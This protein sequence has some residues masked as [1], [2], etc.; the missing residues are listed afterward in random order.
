MRTYNHWLLAESRERIPLCGDGMILLRAT[1]F[2]VLCLFFL[3]NPNLLTEPVT[4]QEYVMWHET[5]EGTTDDWDADRGVWEAGIPSNPNGPGKAFEG[6]KCAAI[7]CRLNYPNNV[8]SSFV[9]H[10]FFVV[11]PRDQNPRLRFSHWFSIADGDFGEVIVIAGAAFSISPRYYGSSDWT[12]ASVDLG[13]Y[14]GQRV[15]I[16]FHFTSNGQGTSGGWFIDDVQLV[17]GDYAFS[18]FEGFECGLGDWAPSRGNWKV[19]T[20]TSG[21]GKAYRGQNCTAPAGT[22]PIDTELV[23]PRFKVPAA[24]QNPRLRFWHWFSITSGDIALY[25]NPDGGGYY[26]LDQYYGSSG[27]WTRACVDLGKWAGQQVRVAFHASS[28]PGTQRNGWFIDDV[29]L[30]TGDYQFSGLEGFEGGLGDWATTHGNLWKVGTPANGP[31]KAFN[32]QNCAGVVLAGNYP[33][34]ATSALV[35]P[36]F[37]VPAASQSPRLRFWHWFSI[38]NGDYGEVGLLQAGTSHF[39]SPLY[40]GSSGDWTRTSVD[41]GSYAGQKV[42]IVFQFRSDGQGTSSGW[43]IDDVE[44]LPAL[45]NKRPV[46]ADIPTQVASRGTTVTFTAK[47][48]DPNNDTLTY[49]LDPNTAPA[50]ATIDLNAGV[51]TWTPTEAQLRMNACYV[52]VRVTDS[53]IP[54][55]SDS[56]IVPIAM[57]GGPRLFLSHPWEPFRVT[58]VGGVPGMLYTAEAS[59]NLQSWGTPTN[60]PCWGTLTNFTLQARGEAFCY[61]D[62]DLPSTVLRFF[63]VKGIRPEP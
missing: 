11:P 26:P 5:F 13:S 59:T 36:P 57:P 6:T 3:C 56:K 37:T 12:R 10:S 39:I 55:L 49:T 45:D 28:P 15:Q 1:R 35:S 19:G 24:S 9:R 32:G 40:Y 23:S 25:L 21:P 27:G 51:F 53:G 31:G 22:N 58:V 48:T 54:P 43:F 62:K 29:Q 52:T 33:N 17:T 63:R 46:L 41:L 50:G 38:L 7:G 4:A 44:L 61:E 8:D 47:A 42:Q 34:N 30:V 20:P 18:G 60:C 14:A 2:L 16:A